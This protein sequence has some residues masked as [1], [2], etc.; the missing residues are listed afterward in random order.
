MSS[1]K[2]KTL[3]AV[4]AIAASAGPGHSISSDY[5]QKR[6]KRHAEQVNA[7][8]K[9]QRVREQIRARRAAKVGAA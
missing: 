5:L 6:D 9:K 2:L 4:A 3:L 8:A 1:L 7:L